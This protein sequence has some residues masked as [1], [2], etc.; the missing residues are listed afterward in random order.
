VKLYNWLIAFAAGVGGFLCGY[1]IGIIKWV[2]DKIVIIQ[3]FERE[4]ARGKKKKRKRERKEN[5][6]V[7]IMF[8]PQSDFYN[9]ELQREVRHP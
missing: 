5:W 3:P 4:N 7:L 1:E 8:V 2:K 6:V 9:G